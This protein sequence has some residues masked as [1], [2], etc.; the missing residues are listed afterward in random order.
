MNGNKLRLALHHRRPVTGREHVHHSDRGSA[1]TAWAFQTQLRQ[2][3]H[4]PGQRGRGDLLC[5]SEGRAHRPAALTLTCRRGASHLRFCRKVVQPEASARK[6]WLPHPRRPRNLPTVCPVRS[7]TIDCPMNGCKSSPG[8][9]CWWGTADV[10]WMVAMPPGRRP[11][12]AP[13][14]AEAVA[15]REKAYLRARFE[16]PFGVIKRQFGNMESRYRALVE[17]GVAISDTVRAWQT[18][19]W[20][21]APWWQGRLPRRRR[22][23][24]RNDGGPGRRAK[25]LPPTG[26]A[27]CARTRG[28]GSK[29]PA[30]N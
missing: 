19:G 23:N 28:H 26:T 17:N 22:P 5:N 9:A 8:V 25:P 3:G 27:A 21:G 12:L 20:H 18:S 16:H 4:L 24:S 13:G 7:R 11:L 6:P 2:A 29:S 14:S 10:A 30:S 15:Q 1:Y